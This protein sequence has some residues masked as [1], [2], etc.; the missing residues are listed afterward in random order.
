MIGE[1]P[2]RCQPRYGGQP[3][4]FDILTELMEHITLGR[5]H[6]DGFPAIMGFQFFQLAVVFIARVGHKGLFKQGALRRC[7]FLGRLARCCATAREHGKQ[8]SRLGQLFAVRARHQHLMRV[9][10]VDMQLAFTDP[11]FKPCAKAGIGRDMV[12]SKHSSTLHPKLD[13]HARSGALMPPDCESS[14]W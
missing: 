6:V 10:P 7:Q 14:F 2:G 12:L 11:L 5:L 9:Q 4:S 1:V 13:S 8:I 3:A